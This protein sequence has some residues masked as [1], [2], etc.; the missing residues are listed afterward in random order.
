MTRC[1]PEQ[2][3][4][5]RPRGVAAQCQAR[6][7]NEALERRNVTAKAGVVRVALHCECG[8]PLCR[9]TVAPTHSE[10]EAV[11]AF[12]SRFIVGVNHEDPESAC[13]LH[14]TSRFAVIDIVAHDPRYA[15]LACNPRHAW[16]EPAPFKKEP[17][18]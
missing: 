13:V 1:S 18:R 12:G 16:V 7:A 17:G 15:A 4:S 10:Y 14:E 11:R 2:V 8:D 3:A 9:A 5:G 6:E